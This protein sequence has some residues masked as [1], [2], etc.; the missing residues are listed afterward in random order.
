DKREEIGN[1]HWTVAGKVKRITRTPGSTKP[2]LVFAYGAGG[3]RIMK[4]VGDPDNGGYREHYIRDAQGNIMAIY[5]YTNSGTASTKVVERPVYGSSRLGSYALAQEVMGTWLSTYPF[6]QLLSNP[7][8]RYEL[9]DHLGNVSTVVSGRL[10][11]GAGAGSPKQAEVITASGYEPFGALLPGR[12][13]RQPLGPPPPPVTPQGTLVITE[14][15]NGPSGDCEYVEL[16]VTKCSLYP[17]AT[18]VDIRGWIVDDNGGNLNSEGGCTT[19]VGISSGHL[20]LAAVATWASVPVGSVIVLYNG[21]DNCYAFTAQEAGTG[22]QYFVNVNSTTLIERTGSGGTPST[23]DCGY[24]D[25]SY[26]A[27]SSSPS[28]WSTIAMGNSG[29]G[30]QVRCP[31]CPESEAGFFHG[32]GYGADFGSLVAGTNDLGAG[33]FAGTGSQRSYELT[34]ADCTELGADAGWTR[35]TAPASGTPPA[36]AGVVD[37]NV[38]AW[39]EEC[40]VPCCGSFE[41]PAVAQ[42]QGYRFGFNGKENDNEVYGATGT[43]QDYG[44]RAYD[45]RVGRFFSVDPIANDYPWYSP[46][47]FAGNKPIWAVDLDGLE[48]FFRTDFYV[49]GEFWKTELNVASDAGMYANGLSNVQRVHNSRADITGNEV[50]VT[51]TGSTMGANVLTDQENA[52]VHRRTVDVNGKVTQYGVGSSPPGYKAFEQTTQSKS[53]LD[54]VK[55]RVNNKDLEI[56]HLGDTKTFNENKGVAPDIQLPVG[57]NAVPKLLKDRKDAEGHMV[58]GANTFLGLI[59]AAG[60]EKDTQREFHGTKITVEGTE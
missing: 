11:D 27:T 26:T 46:Y 33:H 44:E 24:C 23:S 12:N 52:V 38:L 13:W 6:T 32:L 22:G 45:T 47:Q 39:L 60:E 16:Y 17:D 28:S 58:G 34:G 5:K 1:I 37:A 10:L 36:T 42:K 30:I 4:Q 55:E 15:S 59:K 9:T 21:N 53:N 7:D 48:E 41:A 19:G 3:Q 25:N 43:F 14:F 18:E 31:D 51:Y 54:D 20:R 49:N 50:V 57:L 8:K 56:R 40:S 35:T 29:D 2:E